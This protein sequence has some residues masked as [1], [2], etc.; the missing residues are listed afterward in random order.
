MYIYLT[1]IVEPVVLIRISLGF[2]F[3]LPGALLIPIIPALVQANAAPDVEL[4]GL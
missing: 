2:P 3:P 4:R 1:T